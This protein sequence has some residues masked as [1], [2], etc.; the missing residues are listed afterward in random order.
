V[1][2]PCRR[3]ALWIIK[4]RRPSRDGD[5]DGLGELHTTR[6]VPTLQERTHGQD[7]SSCEGRRGEGQRGFATGVSEARSHRHRGKK[8]PTL[9]PGRE[10]G[11]VQAQDDDPPKRSS[12][13]VNH[14]VPR[15]YRTE[16]KTPWGIPAAKVA[17]ASREHARCGCTQFVWVADIGWTHR[18]S[19]PPGGRK[20]CW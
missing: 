11:R 15:Y 14:P 12:D 5:G 4:R 16:P 18:A 3:K 19:S 10:A 13:G 1:K 8:T 6:P 17:R 20:T 7:C 2:S 9:I